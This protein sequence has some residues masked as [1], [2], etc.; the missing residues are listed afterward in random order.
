MKKVGIEGWEGLSSA[1][2]VIDEAQRRFREGE[3]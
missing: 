2:R 1:L 3:G